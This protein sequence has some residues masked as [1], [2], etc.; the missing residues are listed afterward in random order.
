M[1]TLHGCWLEADRADSVATELLRIRSVL[2]PMTS[3][4]SSP[5]SAH[6]T[7]LS[8]PS[9]DHE[10]ITAILR[11][12]EQ[13]SRLLRDLHDLFPIYRLR[14]AIVIY[15]LTVILPCLQRTLRDMLEFLTCEDFSPRVKWALMHERLNEQG[16]MSL[17]L[18]FVMYGDFLVQLVR[19]LSR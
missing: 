9:F 12:V 10:I 19:L 18:R 7:S 11:H 4:S 8:A 15:Y 14:V 1:E 16:G 5:S 2:N 6:A 13:T 17:A 3:S